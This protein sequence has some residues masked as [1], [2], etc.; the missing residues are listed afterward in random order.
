M[1]RYAVLL[2]MALALGPLMQAY[3]GTGTDVSP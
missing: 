1:I 3:A 2:I